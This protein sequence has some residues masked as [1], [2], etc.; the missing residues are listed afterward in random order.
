MNFYDNVTEAMD[1]NEYCMGIFIDLSKA[2]DT[3]DHDILLKKLDIYGIRG[4]ANNLIKSYLQ[5]RQQ[6]VV[7]NN[8]ESNCQMITCGVPQGSIL[9]PLLFLLYINDMAHF[10]KILTLISVLVDT[11]ILYTNSDIWELERLVNT[12]LLILSDWFKANRLSL[13]IQKT[14]Y[15]LFGYKHIP[16]N[17]SRNFNIKIDN[18]AISRVETTKFLGI[19]IDEKLK[20]Q[21]HIS[22]VALK[23]AKSLGILYRLKTKLPKSCLLT[24]YYSLIYPHL[25]YCNIV[26]GGAAKAIIN[27]LVVLQKRAIPIITNSNYRSNTTALFKELHILKLEDINMH[28]CCVFMYKFICKELPNVCSTSLVLHDSSNALYNF[29]RFS[30]FIIP[31]FRTSVR[32]KCISIRGP[33]YW[34]LLPTIVRS[35][36]SSNSFNVKLRKYILCNY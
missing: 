14:N 34:E 19:I 5:N 32:E 9:G 4:I 13:N 10:S 7:Y 23:L 30:L 1:K 36:P 25:T 24:V 31:K 27:E 8:S 35:A 16:K 28:C 20:W 15:M 3:L 18:I 17:N 21:Y 26:W 11:N 6:Y 33:R 12:E 2:F 29:R 22:Y